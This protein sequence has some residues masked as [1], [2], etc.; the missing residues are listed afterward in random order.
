MTTQSY[1]VIVVLFIMI[2]C[3]ST[4]VY[5]ETVVSLGGRYD[6][7]TNDLSP[8]SR[9]TELTIPFGAI[10]KRERWLVRS[11]AC[12]VMPGSNPTMRPTLPAVPSSSSFQATPSA[13]AKSPTSRASKNSNGA[14]AR[15]S[16]IVQ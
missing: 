5:A 12:W 8:K 15:T 11:S 14:F 4:L 3:S 2:Y 16:R 7:F 6:T 10:Y 9:G 1:S 13:H